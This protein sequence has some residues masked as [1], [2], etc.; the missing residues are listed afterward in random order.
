LHLSVKTIET[1][2]ENIKHKLGLRNAAELI[3]LATHWVQTSL[4]NDVAS[5]PAVRA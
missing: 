5:P 3:R 1:Y 4:S 2:R